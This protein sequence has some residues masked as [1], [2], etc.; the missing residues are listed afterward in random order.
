MEIT[1]TL[2][3]ELMPMIESAAQLNGKAIPDYLAEVVEEAVSEPY[4]EQL[5][6]LLL[7]GLDSGPVTPMTRQDWDD[8]KAQGLARLA[9]KQA[10]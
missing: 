9:A 7:E 2:R 10:R 4:D 5:E 8:I 6:K 3:P 1:I